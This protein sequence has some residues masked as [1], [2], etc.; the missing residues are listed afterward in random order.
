[1]SDLKF[2]ARVIF[3]GFFISASITSPLR[4]DIVLLKN[5]NAIET[6]ILRED[7]KYL[8]VQAPGGKVKIAKNE[9]KTLW[10]GEA[11]DSVEVRGKEVFFAKG[12]AFYKEG[13]FREAAESFEQ[14]IGPDA[15]N[16]VIYANLGSSYASLGEQQ[17][18]EENFLKALE[19]KPNDPVILL[20]LAQLY[21][22][23]HRFSN[24]IQTCQTIL[25]KDP[26]HQEAAEK[27][28]YCYYVTGNFEES[29]RYYK[30]LK[31]NNEAP[32]LNNQASAL[33][34]L[35]RLKEAL[36]ILERLTSGQQATSGRIIFAKPYFNLA[37][38][39]RLQKQYKPAEDQYS[40]VL[41][42]DPKNAEAKIGLGFLFLEMGDN[43]K[44]E[45]IFRE[46]SNIESDSILAR[47]G[48]AKAL[49]KKGAYSEAA[50][51]YRSILD[52]EPNNLFAHNDL[53]LLYLKLNQPKNA[54]EAF[55]ETLKI[56]GR[57][58]KGHANAGLTYAL[59]NDADN[60]LKEWNRALELDPKLEPALQNKKL[61]EEAMR[62]EQIGKKA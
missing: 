41:A 18:A 6:K 44:A 7:E 16:A 42:K 30:T 11:A 48:L 50:A 52:K 27:L 56:D 47:Y 35:G 25:L 40:I 34:R 62:G 60:A 37:E 49:A 8:T 5:G 31:R 24:A 54:L 12:V 53:G 32:F 20:N 33:I 3:F 15:A 22:S 13:K 39:Y 51:E 28:A 19:E 43:E 23:S 36:A 46:A 17:K 38:I 61:L 45:T 14:A 26:S 21:Q 55:Q 29:L 2:K 57:Y 59:M 58:A 9:I 10:R 1:M 4:A